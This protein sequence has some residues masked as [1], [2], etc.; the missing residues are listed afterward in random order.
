MSGRKPRWRTWVQ[1]SAALLLG[2]AAPPNYSALSG[3]N[4]KVYC[5]GPF[6]GALPARN[7]VNK[8]DFRVAF[9]AWLWQSL[10]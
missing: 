5:A 8:Y 2:A 10:T 4:L 3:I 7:A 6:T 9:L 1:K